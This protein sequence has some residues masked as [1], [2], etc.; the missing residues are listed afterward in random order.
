MVIENHVNHD[1]FF[2]K[3]LL[4]FFC[5]SEVGADHLLDVWVH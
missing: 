3:L 2:F 1:V 5:D 4:L